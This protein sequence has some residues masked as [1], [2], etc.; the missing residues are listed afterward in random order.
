MPQYYWEKKKKEQKT[1]SKTYQ[2]FAL[3]GAIYPGLESNLP[4]S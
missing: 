4:L 1:A 2:I 3:Q